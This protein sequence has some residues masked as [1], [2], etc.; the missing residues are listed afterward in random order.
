MPIGSSLLTGSA[1]SDIMSDQGLSARAKSEADEIAE[2][3]RK[4]KLLDDQNQAAAG[5]AAVNPI[6]AVQ[7]LLG[8]Q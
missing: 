5:V 2:K 4:K 7:S 3:M 1:A 8:G 6:G